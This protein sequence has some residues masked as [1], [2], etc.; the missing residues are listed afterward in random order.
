MEAREIYEEKVFT[1]EEVARIFK[2]S[3]S[4]VRRLI[5]EGELP[6]IR[7]GR[8]YRVPKSVI[9]DYFAQPAITNFTPE[10]LGFGLWRDRSDVE[11]GVEYVNRL[12]DKN[13]KSLRE[14]VAE[15]D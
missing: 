14:T 3:A 5:H 15:L 10:D 9:D 12:R 4:S 7:L 8:R 11:D 13:A 6:A 2:L 1:V